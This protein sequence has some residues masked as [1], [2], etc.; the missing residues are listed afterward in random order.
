MPSIDYRELRRRISMAEVLQLLG[1][2]PI[3]VRGAQL[4]GH[5]PVHG[6]S[7]AVGRPKRTHRPPFSVNLHKQAYQCFEC[8]SK[9]NALKLWASV[10][11]LPLHPA[12]FD[13]CQ[14]LGITPPL[15]P[16]RHG[17]THP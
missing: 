4:R 15:L 8:G 10:H 16:T 11:K 6:R 5:C 9:G 1:F 7:A 14:T 2:Q 12:A 17:S 3:K 13:L